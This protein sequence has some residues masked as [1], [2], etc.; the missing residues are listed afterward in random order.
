[1]TPE[2]FQILIVLGL[3]VTAIV[4]FARETFPVD[5]T[6]LLMLAALVISGVLTPQEAFAG[7]SSDIIITLASIFALTGALQQTGVV[8]FV[9]RRLRE[10]AAVQRRARQ[11]GTHPGLR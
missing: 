5:V 11:S 10:I 9:G 6:T 3:L 2:T 7:F 1:M 4:L 8:D